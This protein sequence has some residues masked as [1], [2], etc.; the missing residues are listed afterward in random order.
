MTSKKKLRDFTRDYAIQIRR[1]LAAPQESILQRA[2]ELGRRA[3]ADGLGVLDVASSQQSALLVFLNGAAPE[4]C[5]HTIR[6]SGEFLAESLSPFEMTHRSFREANSSMRDLTSR[7]EDRVQERTHALRLAEEKYRGIFEN[8]SEGIYLSRQ[9]RYVNVN[10]AYA[11]ILGFNSPVEMI[12]WIGRLGSRLYLERGRYKQL[13]R[14]ICE[15]GSALGFESR[16]RRKD[17]QVIWISENASRI[18]GAD[19]SVWVEG[20][21]E[22]VTRRKES[23]E[24]L[25]RQALYDSLTELPNRSLFLDRLEQ[26]FQRASHRGGYEFAVLFIDLDHFKQ[27]NDTLG[28]TAGDELLKLIARRLLDCLRPQD[29]IGRMGGDEFTVLLDGVHDEKQATRVLERLRKG[30]NQPFR[31]G[32]RRVHATASMGV[33]LSKDGYGDADAILKHADD[34]MYHS[35]TLKNHYKDLISQSQGNGSQHRERTASRK[36]HAT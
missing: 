31:L 4:E 22:D 1:Y 32:N 16:V 24:K 3:V 25:A 8:A 12:K 13:I 14:Q 28:H 34:Q 33:A 11:R 30:L 7:L 20:V 26:A 35:R 29:T 6:L 5:L 19:G 27:I 17:G 2:Y 36:G 23:E 9:D 21:V 18:L 15:K 10:P